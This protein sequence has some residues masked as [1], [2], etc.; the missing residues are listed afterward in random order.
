MEAELKC[1]IHETH[2]SF[3]AAGPGAIQYFTTA[4]VDGPVGMLLKCPGC[5]RASGMDFKPRPSPSWKWNGNRE[6]PTLTP[7]IN[8]VGCCQWHGWLSQGV[9][10]T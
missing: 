6:N 5:G 9:F 4:G 7:S 10:F 3:E 2:E 8:C 1:S